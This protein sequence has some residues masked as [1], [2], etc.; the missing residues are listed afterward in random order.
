MTYTL[1]NIDPNHLRFVFQFSTEEFQQAA[2]EYAEK[3]QKE[4]LDAIRSQGS[5]RKPVIT[6]L[7]RK[8]YAKAAM[9]YPQEIYYTPALTLEQDDQRGIVC[10]ARVQIAPAF[11][12]GDYHSLSISEA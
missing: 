12:L 2:K 11:T 7:V 6:E 3:N 10:S 4:Y 5:F 8:A 9:E 1:E